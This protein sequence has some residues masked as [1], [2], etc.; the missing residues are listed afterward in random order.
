MRNDRIYSL[1]LEDMTKSPYFDETE[2]ER[3]NFKLKQAIKNLPGTTAID[4]SFTQEDGKTCK[5]SEYK[6]KKII[7]YF[8]DPECENCH[9]VSA[10]LKKQEIPA[11]IQVIRIVADNRISAIYGLKAMPTIYLLDKGNKVILKDC[12]PEQ[13]IETVL[14]K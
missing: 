13:L 10:W 7:L 9:K 4:I 8:H 14:Q 2:K 6:E 1:F 11:D 5:L 12:T 3:L